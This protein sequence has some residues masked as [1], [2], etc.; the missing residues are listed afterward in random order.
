MAFSQTLRNFQKIMLAI[1]IIWLCLFF[2][3]VSILTKTLIVGHPP[4]R[5]SDNALSAH[6]IVKLEKL[7]SGKRGTR[8]R[9]INYMPPVIFRVCLDLSENPYSRTAS[10]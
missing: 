8:L 9:D 2:K 6:I 7:S 4:R 10:W 3:N 5:L 1:S